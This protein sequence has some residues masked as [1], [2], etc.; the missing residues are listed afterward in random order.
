MT[1]IQKLGNRTLYYDGKSYYWDKNKKQKCS[2]AAA[3]EFIK[4]ANTPQ[5]QAMGELLTQTKKLEKKWKISFEKALLLCCQYFKI[6]TTKL[7][8]QDIGFL[9]N[10][11]RQRVQEIENKTVGRLFFDSSTGKK[12]FR[13]GKIYKALRENKCDYILK[14]MLN[15]FD[16]VDYLYQ[17]EDVKI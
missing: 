9:F 15:Y 12:T 1:L 13:P 2:S 11:S 7:T 4:Y 8:L 3:N 10:I 17:G 16:E 14:D 5:G 6:D